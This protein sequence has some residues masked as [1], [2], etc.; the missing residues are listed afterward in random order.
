MIAVHLKSSYG[1]LFHLHGFLKRHIHGKR[2]LLFCGSDSACMLALSDPWR[3]FSYF[4]QPAYLPTDHRIFPFSQ[5][6]WWV[7]MQYWPLLPLELGY[8]KLQRAPLLPKFDQIS[9]PLGLGETII[10]SFFVHF[11]QFI[12]VI[13][14]HGNHTG[15]RWALSVCGWRS[16]CTLIFV[17]CGIFHTATPG[18]SAWGCL[19]SSPFGATGTLGV[20]AV[21]PTLGLLLQLHWLTLDPLVEDRSGVQNCAWWMFGMWMDELPTMHSST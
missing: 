11:L 19:I 20:H 15:A 2:L 17:P 14:S 4:G 5:F 12:W 10:D 21:G 13:L 1:H 8:L 16:W 9:L 3:P 7:S 18:V 6:W